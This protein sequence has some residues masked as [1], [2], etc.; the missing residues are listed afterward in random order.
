MDMKA[1][2]E[3]WKGMFYFVS[4]VTISVFLYLVVIVWQ[5]L[6]TEGFRNFGAISKAIIRLDRTAKPV[7]EMAPLMLGEMDEMRKAMVKMQASMDTI[8]KLDPS[9]REINY[10]MNRM[11]WIMERR[12]G[13]MTGEM[14]RLGD[15]MS[16]AGMMPFNW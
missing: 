3:F 8:E 12:M 2:S 4:T 15:K 9:V 5:P 13:A 11:N 7:A 16:P 10:T 1:F 6:W 14:D